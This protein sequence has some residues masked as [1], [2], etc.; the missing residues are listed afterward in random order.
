MP[1]LRS[2][3]IP[4]I[5]DY[6]TT[7]FEPREL[8]HQITDIIT[9]RPEIRLCYVG[10]GAKCF[11]ILESPDSGP[12]SSPTGPTPP[13][14]SVDGLTNGHLNS[15]SSNIAGMV[16]TN[17]PDEEEE[18]EDTTDEEDEGE[19]DDSEESEEEEDEDTTPTTGT[20]D[21]DETQSDNEAADHDDYSDDD[22]F[23]EPNN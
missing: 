19:D 18:E 10:I 5:A 15:S 2:L 9:L 17:Q 22:G 1:Q 20:S 16:A 12:S 11:E 13:Y 4:Y 14:A 21:P 8:A 7:T 3:N 6:I 23:F